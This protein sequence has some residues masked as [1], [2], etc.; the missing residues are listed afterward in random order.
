MHSKKINWKKILDAGKKKILHP[1]FLV[2]FFFLFHTK[3]INYYAD[4][5]PVL[6][7]LSILILSAVVIK[8]LSTWALKDSVKGGIISFAVLFILLFYGDIQT[9][10]AEMTVASEFVR[11]R[12]LL[13]FFLLSFSL[14]FYFIKKSKRSFVRANLLLNTLTFLYF[15][16]EIGSSIYI[17]AGQRHLKVYP[18]ETSADLLQKMKD[19]KSNNKNKKALPDIYFILL[20]SYTSNASLRKYWNYDNDSLKTFLHE[21]GFT[22]VDTARSNYDFTLPSLASIFGMNY[23]SQDIMVNTQKTEMKFALMN[24][25]KKSPFLKYIN[26]NGYTIINRSPFDIMFKRKYYVNANQLS[27]LSALFYYS[28]PSQLMRDLMWQVAKNERLYYFLKPHFKIWENNKQ[29]LGELYESTKHVDSI[30]IFVYAHP[31]L[32]HFPY[33]FDRYGNVY[34]DNNRW[35]FETKMDQSKYFDQLIYTNKLLIESINNI[36]D[37]SKKTPI[38]I[39][40]SD[41]GFRYLKEDTEHTEDHTI[42]YA[43]LVP[44]KDKMIQGKFGN[45]VNNFRIILNHYFNTKLDLLPYKSYFSEPA[46]QPRK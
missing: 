23:L 1:Y 45:P 33:F 25:V 29:V 39:I 36:L 12:Y 15:I 18:D 44:K 21:H 22:I 41:H 38:I 24:A 35:S 32:P 5:F 20:D 30:P 6:F 4:F 16:F 46:A 9:Q 31:M 19:Q 13:I 7:A 28:L 37:A 2:L 34:S 42:F 14:L 17:E 11:H 43:V 8:L 27:Y 3:S 10:L 40:Q 26:N